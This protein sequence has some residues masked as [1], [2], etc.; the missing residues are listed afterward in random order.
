MIISY[1]Y[2][3]YPDATT[4]GRLNTALDTCRW[5][6]NKPLEECNATKENGFSPTMRGMQARIVT[7]KEE[8][9]FLKGVYSKRLQMVNY[10]LWS[11]ICALSQTKKSGTVPFAMHRPYEGT[12]KGVL[13][14]RSGDAW[15]VI[16]QAEREVSEPKKEGRSV[17]IDVG[18]TSFAVDSDGTAIE[19][20]RFFE[21]SKEKIKK[22]QRN[23]AR[24]KRFSKNWMKVKAKLEKIYDHITNQKRDFLHKLSRRYVDEYA[25]ICVEDLN[26]KYLKEQGTSR[27]LRRSIHDASWG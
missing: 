20:P 10:T 26:I 13:I 3:A 15:Y 23:L 27:G 19:N 2:R 11:N 12:V 25:T 8:N 6:Y 14:T 22:L 18:L 21:Q 7:L 9:P 24:K 16:I 4:E 17:G 1:T 5:L